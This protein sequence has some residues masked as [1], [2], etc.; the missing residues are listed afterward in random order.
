V[1]A[2]ASFSSRDPRVSLRAP[3]GEALHQAR[4]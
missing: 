4:E 1:P 3:E 2:K